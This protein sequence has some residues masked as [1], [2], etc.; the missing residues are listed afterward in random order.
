MTERSARDTEILRIL[1]G[2][3][4]IQRPDVDRLEAIGDRPLAASLLASGLLDDS[5]LDHVVAELRSRSRDRSREAARLLRLGD[6]GQ[7]A[8]VATEA[9]ELDPNDPTARVLRALARI[10]SGDPASARADLDH[11]IGSDR[12]NAEA[13]RVRGLLAFLDGDAGSAARD[14]TA[15]LSLRPSARTYFDR[16]LLFRTEGEHLSALLDLKRSVD[17][18][19]G[20]GPAR[21][22]CGLVLLDTG[23]REE[24]IAELRSGWRVARK[25]RKLARLVLTILRARGVDPSELRNE[26]PAPI[27]SENA[28]RPPVAGAHARRPPRLALGAPALVGAV[29]LVL[30]VRSGG[31]RPP[32]VESALPT[33]AIA[34][35]PDVG[36]AP[37][38]SP[39]RRDV[40]A[41][42]VRWSA[43]ELTTPQYEDYLVREMGLSR[44]VAAAEVEEN[45]R[46]LAAVR[47]RR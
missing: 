16:G 5:I 37:P 32:Q 22:A 10:R 45:R 24:S 25:D 14:L 42:A 40:T 11:A 35:A 28:G 23:R 15:S 19:P 47:S 2:S 34:V 9:L 44:P 46:L 12:G 39:A 7:A 8:A 6:A 21:I 4:R 27:R 13:L 30:L 33:R 1:R 29:F 20:W 41:E 38:E 36:M 3:G 17:L 26:T 18:D 31:A 43:A